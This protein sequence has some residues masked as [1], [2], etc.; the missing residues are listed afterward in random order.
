M[1]TVSLTKKDTLDTN[2]I[3]NFV[4]SVYPRLIGL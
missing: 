4:L 2:L 1:S 3:Y